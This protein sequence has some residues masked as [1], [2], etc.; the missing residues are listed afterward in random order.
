MKK[1]IAHCGKI[2]AYKGFSQWKGLFEKSNLSYNKSNRK[3]GDMGS[4]TATNASEIDWLSG[5]FSYTVLAKK[6]W[7]SSN[8]FLEKYSLKSLELGFQNS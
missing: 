8:K 2:V 6:T 3:K 1:N 7:W 4:Q 5:S